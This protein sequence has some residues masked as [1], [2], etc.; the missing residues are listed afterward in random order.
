MGIFRRLFPGAKKPAPPDKPVAIPVNPR[1]HK[2]VKL[3]SGQA[4]R[5]EGRTFA[6]PGTGKPVATPVNRPVAQRQAMTLGRA[7]VP[8]GRRTSTPVPHTMVDAFLAG[9]K[10]F[11]TSS[12]LAYAEYHRQQRELEIGFLD[13]FVAT[14]EDIDEALAAT[15]YHAPSK[16]GF[17][18]DYLL[19]PGWVPGRRETARKRWH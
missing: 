9:T 14:Y 15:F 16:G 13:G 10:T 4:P 5:V 6:L 1:V 12:W 17:V 11:V 8:T 19:G 18:H 3:P 7:E 2:L